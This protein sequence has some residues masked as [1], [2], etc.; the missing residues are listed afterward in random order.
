MDTEILF[1]FHLSLL[2]WSIVVKNH[3]LACFFTSDLFSD[4]LAGADAKSRPE[5]SGSSSFI[6]SMT[7]PNLSSPSLEKP[8]KA[9]NNDIMDLFDKVYILKKQFP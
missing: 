9:V 8:L 1:F 7:Q 6:E 2:D 5:R 3:L 4:L